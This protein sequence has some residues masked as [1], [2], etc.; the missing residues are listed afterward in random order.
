MSKA[1][2]RYHVCL[3]GRS[4]STR[5]RPF[6]ARVP[7]NSRILIDLH[8]NFADEFP[9]NC[10]PPGRIGLVSIASVSRAVI[11]TYTVRTATGLPGASNGSRAQFSAMHVDA[12]TELAR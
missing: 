7:G 3:Q 8:A 10:A 6:N 9:E 1:G 12:A 5:E 11:P 2:P 4:R